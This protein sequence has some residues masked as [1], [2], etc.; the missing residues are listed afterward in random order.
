MYNIT[1]DSLQVTPDFI[2]TTNANERLQ[3][4]THIDIAN[5]N[6]GK[7]FTHHSWPS[8]KKILDP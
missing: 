8:E 1:L 7:A 2:F 6:K 4:E 5:L 3:L